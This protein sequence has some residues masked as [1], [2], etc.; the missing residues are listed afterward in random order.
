MHFIIFGSCFATSA[1]KVEGKKKIS[2]SS[3]RSTG[4]HFV[5]FFLSYISYRPYLQSLCSSSFLSQNILARTV[6]GDWHPVR[7][8]LV[9]DRIIC[10]SPCPIHK[11]SLQSALPQALLSPKPLV[12]VGSCGLREVEGAC[13]P[14]SCKVCGGGCIAHTFIHL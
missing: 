9:P 10:L 12:L 2:C 5:I 8:I 11:F 4:S 6:I 1:R 14:W 3:A 7:R 13:T